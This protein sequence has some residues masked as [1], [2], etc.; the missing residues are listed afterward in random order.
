MIVPV[1]AAMYAG[2]LVPLA[3][4]HSSLSFSYK[5]STFLLLLEQTTQSPASW[6]SLGISS[7][8][9]FTQCLPSC[10]GTVASCSAKL[11]CCV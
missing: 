10:V 6:L 8:W 2:T 5:S 3:W 4:R 1:S 7:G 9:C 11:L